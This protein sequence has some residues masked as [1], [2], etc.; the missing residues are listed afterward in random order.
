MAKKFLYYNVQAMKN[1]QLAGAR[2]CRWLG[3]F[4]CYRQAN[5]RPSLVKT[6][7]AQNQPEGEGSHAQ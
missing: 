4:R 3:R 6:L 1:F 5:L 2:R 7:L